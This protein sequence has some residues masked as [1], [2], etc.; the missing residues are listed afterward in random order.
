MVSRKGPEKSGDG[1]RMQP[2]WLSVLRRRAAF[3]NSYIDFERGI[4]VGRLE[5]EERITR[6][7]KARLTERFAIRFICDRWGRGVFWQWICWVPEP[8]R[9]AKPKSSGMN[10]SSGKFFVSVDRND[11]ILQAGVQIERAPVEPDPDDWPIRLERDWDWHVFVRALKGESLQRLLRR[12]TREGFLIRL[13]PF[14]AM[15]T[16]GR[17]NYDPSA[18]RAVLR[19][20]PRNAWGG[21]QLYWPFGEEEVRGT[22]GGELIEAV[23]AAFE[24]TAPVLDLC[25]Y[26]PCLGTKSSSRQR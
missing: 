20:F 6:I 4:R 16:F 17:S 13:G 24:E 11:R 12:L 1:S 21:F 22:E 26:A 23:V 10:F 2:P 3:K 14:G 25:M 5:P 7:L 9:K 18:L 15:K 19:K 8:N